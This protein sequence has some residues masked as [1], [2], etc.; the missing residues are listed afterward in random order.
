VYQQVFELYKQRS[1]PAI[2]FIQTAT[3]TLI[4]SHA[5]HCLDDSTLLISYKLIHWL[6]K[7]PSFITLTV[8]LILPLLAL[9]SPL[10]SNVSTPS[11]AD[12]PFPKRG[13]IFHNPSS[14]YIQSWNGAGSQVNWAY[15]W[16]SVMDNTFPEWTEY[17]PMLWGTSSDHTSGARSLPFPFHSMFHVR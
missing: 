14:Q 6:F 1:V 15:N 4:P 7:M 13:L 3:L 17:I 12:A 2:S 5:A 10:Y 16:D 8:A 11:S 9:S